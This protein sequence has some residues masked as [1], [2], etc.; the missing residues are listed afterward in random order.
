MSYIDQKQ[1]P[2][3][4][5][6]AS[7]LIV[8]GAIGA[9]V[10]AGL[11]VATGAAVQD[12]APPLIEFDTTPPPPPEP[13]PMP[14]PQPNTEPQT[15]VDPPINAP[16]PPIDF[17]LPKPS[18]E[19]SEIIIERPPNPVPAPKVGPTAIPAPPAPVPTFDPVSAKP[20]NDPGA[21]LSDRDYRS[22]WARRELTGVAKFQLDIAATGKVTG[23]R[24][25]GSTGHPELDEATCSLVQRRARFEPARGSNGEPVAG[26]FVSSVRWQLPE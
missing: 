20:R 1:G 3:P 7:A 21:W 6:L 22:A 18:F 17:N 25:I 11:S 26:K 19:T 2:S 9:L 10:I 15:A 24:I 5:G 4:T 13:E 23:C 12:D 16:K 14:E 8:Q